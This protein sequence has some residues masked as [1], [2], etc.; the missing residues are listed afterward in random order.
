MEMITYYLFSTPKKSI[1]YF[2]YIVVNKKNM[3]ELIADYLEEED[4]VYKPYMKKSTVHISKE[5][6]KKMLKVAE[7]LGVNLEEAISVLVYKYCCKEENNGSI[8]SIIL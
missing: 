5:C 7:R 2:E 4:L 3:P 8:E 6:Y 1:N